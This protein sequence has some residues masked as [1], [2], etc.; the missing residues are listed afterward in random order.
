MNGESEVKA[1]WLVERLMFDEKLGEFVVNSKHEIK[2]D[3]GLLYYF[4]EII[5]KNVNP[6]FAWRISL[7]IFEDEWVKCPNCGENNWATISRRLITS[8]TNIHYVLKCKKCGY[9]LTIE[10]K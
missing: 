6:R 8:P 1:K 9:E 3:D 4:K 7:L 5:L 10:K 2:N